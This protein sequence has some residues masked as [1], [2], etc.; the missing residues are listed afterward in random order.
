MSR[1]MFDMDGVLAD[2][3]L[4]FTERLHDADSS[5]EVRSTLNQPQWDF[6]DAPVKVLK[7]VWAGV[8][9]D[10]AF[11][12]NLRPLVSDVEMT[13]LFGLA[14]EHEP[15]FVTARPGTNVKRQTERWLKH[16][17]GIG[18][19]QVI[20]SPE[21]GEAA[22][23][24]QAHYSIDDKAGNAVYVTYHSRQTQSYIVDRPYN[25]FDHS[26]VGSQVRRVATVG[27]FMAEVLRGKG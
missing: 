3:T 6:D 25:R 16:H 17:I 8:K 20:V 12:Y 24:L 14:L 11:W 27:E 5:I 15:Y 23:F 7:K 19:P 2:F 4:A 9:A 18:N 10:E 13:M 21:K 1:V 26:V 22:R